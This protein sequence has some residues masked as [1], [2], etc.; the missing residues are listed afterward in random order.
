MNNEYKNHK[1]LYTITDQR[2]TKHPNKFN[3]SLIR[4]LSLL[5]MSSYMYIASYMYIVYWECAQ[6]C[7]SL[8]LLLFCRYLYPFELHEKETLKPS[9]KEEVI[10]RNSR[11]KNIKPESPE[12]PPDSSDEKH[13][14]CL[15]PSLDIDE[16]HEEV[17]VKKQSTRIKEM[18][19]QQSRDLENSMLSESQT[20]SPEEEVSVDVVN[21]PESSS[22]ASEPQSDSKSDI[23]VDENTFEVGDKIQV[24]YGRGRNHR[25]YDAKVRYST[26]KFYHQFLK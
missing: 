22:D 4:L 23:P 19:R 14:E 13:L 5:R 21:S 2:N 10:E 12:S 20:K 24:K 25:L 18:K 7:I 16:D 17:I 11:D 3:I 9:V 15:E 26:V 8:F 6:H 1:L